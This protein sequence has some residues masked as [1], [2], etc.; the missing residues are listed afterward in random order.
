MDFGLFDFGVG[1]GVRPGE[2]A[3]HAGRF[4]PRDLPG[5]DGRG[6]A[7][8]RRAKVEHLEAVIAVRPAE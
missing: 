8:G 5:R 4:W 2:F 3:Q 7:G 6:R 1:K